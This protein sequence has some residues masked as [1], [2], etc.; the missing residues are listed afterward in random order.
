MKEQ[1]NANQKVNAD[2]PTFIIE[3]S[4]EETIIPKIYI[5]N[6]SVILNDCIKKEGAPSILECTPTLKEMSE[7]K[8]YKIFY[9]GCIC[10]QFRIT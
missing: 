5:E 4:S 6:S 1:V 9:E 7:T 8:E 2:T 3:L 10:L